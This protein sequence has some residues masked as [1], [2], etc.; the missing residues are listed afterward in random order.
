M[1][2]RSVVGEPP[3][4]R[5]TPQPIVRLEAF[6]PSVSLDS[7]RDNQSVV[8]RGIDTSG[9][10]Y[11]LTDV[12]DFTFGDPSI[13]S[14]EESIIFPLMDGETTLTIKLDGQSVQ[15]RI[16]VANSLDKP[17][18]NFR[19]DVLPAITRS[20]CNNG[21]CHGSAR[22][23]DGFH[24]SLFGYDPAGD[25]QTLT[26]ELPGRR[27]NPALP[28]ESLLL[29][30][31]TGAV[32]HTGGK[33]FTGDDARYR[34]INEWLE[35]VRWPIPANAG[36]RGLG[37]ISAEYCSGRRGC[38]SASHGS[39]GLFG[40]NGSRCHAFGSLHQQQRFRGNSLRTGRGESRAQR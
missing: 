7:A 37:D 31:A 26:R 13:A 10:T 30:K 36:R 33:R 21:A 8:V 39:C 2:A 18:L 3:S 14:V 15:I 5:A 29:L 20:G 11:D 24:L 16:K 1:A 23:Q 19:N 25:Y 22:G 34:S 17:A 38:R 4:D 27:L 35:P 6:P 40:W 32:P 28:A 9:V 12:A